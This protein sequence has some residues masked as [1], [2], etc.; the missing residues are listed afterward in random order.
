MA[1]RIYIETSVFSAYFDDRE[2]VV[3][4][5]QREQTRRWWVGS[6]HYNLFTSVTVLEELKNGVFG[7]K[8]D[9]IGLCLVVPFLTIPHRARELAA[10]YTRNMLMPG[11]ESRDAIHLAIAS[12]H[13]MDFVLTWNCR[14]LANPN[15]VAGLKLVNEEFGLSV[16]GLV[17]PPMLG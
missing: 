17:I 12:I 1:P 9:A 3:S 7:W 14:H 10:A 13:Q 16:P 8:A 4:K 6:I 5:Y 11:G 2:Y 15:K